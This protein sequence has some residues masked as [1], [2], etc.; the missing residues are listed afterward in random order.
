MVAFV[1]ALL[2]AYSHRSYFLLRTL[3]RGT[4]LLRRIFIGANIGCVAHWWE[5]LTYK[6]HPDFER[7][8]HSPSLLLTL[9]IQQIA[10]SSRVFT[11]F[12]RASSNTR[13]H[14]FSYF[15]RTGQITCTLTCLAHAH[16]AEVHIIA[17]RDTQWI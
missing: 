15:G 1:R 4:L 6:E 12:S 13:G 10:S 7:I 11:A 14:S 17:L 5:K 9:C 2:A 3:H 8:R 16:T